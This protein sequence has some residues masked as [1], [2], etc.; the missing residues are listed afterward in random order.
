MTTKIDRFC[1]FLTLL[2]T[3]MNILSGPIFHIAISKEN[4]DNIIKYM[5]NPTNKTLKPYEVN[6]TLA[7][8]SKNKI[9]II[10]NYSEP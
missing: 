9:C 4:F 6:K 10:T 8:N 1:S 2:W 3:L 5:I 7:L